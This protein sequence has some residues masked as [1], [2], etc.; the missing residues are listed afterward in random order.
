MVSPS[1]PRIGPEQHRV[2][3]WGILGSA[4]IAIRQSLIEMLFED[5]APDASALDAMIAG[6]Q[7]TQLAR[8]KAGGMAPDRFRALRPGTVWT[9]E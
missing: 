5:K 9:G 6:A 1:E 3:T 2:L 4:E 8:L 7:A